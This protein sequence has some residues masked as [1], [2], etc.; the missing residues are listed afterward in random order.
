MPN[1]MRTGLAPMWTD[2]GK[3]WDR[4]RLDVGPI[5]V[6]VNFSSQLDPWLKRLFDEE[7]GIHK[8]NLGMSEGLL[9]SY[10]AH[11]DPADAKDPRT[12]SWYKVA[13]HAPVQVL[14]LT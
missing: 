5:A 11:R 1:Q 10:P 12:L 14:F 7:V 13:S 4:S 3:T 9:R 2:P 8:I 6:Q